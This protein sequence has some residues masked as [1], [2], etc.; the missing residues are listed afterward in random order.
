MQPFEVMAICRICVEI[1]FE[2]FTDTKWLSTVNT[3]NASSCHWPSY[4]KMIQ[5]FLDV[6]MTTSGWEYMMEADQYLYCYGIVT[7]YTC[8]PIVPKAVR[9][10]G[11]YKTYCFSFPSGNVNNS[12][13]FMTSTT[14]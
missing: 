11:I 14:I 10:E 3:G 2:A 12:L 7:G 1:A 5:W 9:C 8:H 6:E 13:W 4:N